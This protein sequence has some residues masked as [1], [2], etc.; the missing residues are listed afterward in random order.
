MAMDPTLSNARTY[1]TSQGYGEDAFNSWY[2]KNQGAVAANAGS[3]GD[4]NRVEGAFKKKAPAPAAAPARPAPAA[5]P[6]VDAPLAGL[7]AIDV[8]T[9][10][11]QQAP[12]QAAGGMGMGM[13]EPEPP[14]PTGVES[15]MIGQLRALGRRSLP[16][17][18]YALAGLKKVY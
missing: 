6:P 11:S 1:A 4:W 2:A 7:T 10:T 18:S 13:M 8:G 15:G 17:E 9:S 5:P 16:M 3:G 12:P 14:S